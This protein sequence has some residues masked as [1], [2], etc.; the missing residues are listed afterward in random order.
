MPPKSTNATAVPSEVYIV[1]SAAGPESVHATEDTAEIALKSSKPNSYIEQLVLHGGTV[2][3]DAVPKQAPTTKV[4]P[5]KVDTIK[6]EAKDDENVAAKKTK[7]AAQQR[8]DNANKIGKPD[9]A[10][11]P[12]NVKKLLQKGGIVFAGKTVV[13]TGVPP[14]LGRKN[15][16]K[17]VEAYGAHLGKSLSKKTGYVVVGNEAGPKKCVL[18]VL[19]KC[20]FELTIY[21]LEQIEA[22]GLKT[23]D[24][25]ELI[26]LL[27]NVGDNAKRTSGDDN[28]AATTQPSRSKRQKR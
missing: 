12:V 7:T 17:L 28:D 4:Q 24:E 21:R 14:T 16:E 27:E 9:D 25:D 1:W 10:D 20:L 6:K 23:L 2:N 5:K 26:A 15:T 18:L 3:V 8:T 11:L 22:L 19:S 13:V